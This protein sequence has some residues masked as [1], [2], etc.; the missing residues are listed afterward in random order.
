MLL[1]ASC[2]HVETQPK[3]AGFRGRLRCCL[4]SESGCKQP[5]IQTHG[6]PKFGTSKIT[7]LGCHLSSGMMVEWDEIGAKN[8]RYSQYIVY[9]PLKKSST[10]NLLSMSIYVLFFGHKLGCG[11]RFVT[12]ATLGIWAE[13][14]GWWEV[15]QVASFVAPVFKTKHAFGLSKK[16]DSQLR[17]LG[18]SVYPHLGTPIS[19]GLKNDLSINKCHALGVTPPCWDRYPPSCLCRWWRPTVMVRLVRDM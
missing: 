9:N 3:I 5:G 12:F 4:L 2:C 14:C 7:E 1:S 6:N 18:L 19:T 15:T 11:D 16:D 13:P 10:F 8:P 17:H